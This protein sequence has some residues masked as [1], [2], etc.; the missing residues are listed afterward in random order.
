MIIEYMMS[1]VTPDLL[2]FLLSHEVSPSQS[3][4]H[5]PPAVITLPIRGTMRIFGVMGSPR[6]EKILKSKH[7]PTYLQQR[8]KVL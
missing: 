3:H 6:L 5:I 2:L 1:T 4:L 8:D 7:L